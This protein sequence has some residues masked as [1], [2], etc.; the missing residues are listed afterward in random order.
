MRQRRLPFFASCRGPCP[1]A[2]RAISSPAVR[3]WRAAWRGMQRGTAKP[4]PCQVGRKSRSPCERGVCYAHHLR[5][6]LWCPVPPCAVEQGIACHFNLTWVFGM[7][8]YRKRERNRHTQEQCRLPFLRHSASD[9]LN[10][11]LTEI[12]P[13]LSPSSITLRS[14][15][16]QK[17]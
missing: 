10:K 17:N 4:P 13:F 14:V 3:L 8:W 9:L 1:P 15:Q 7:S 2:R 16:L 6:R 12:E 5:L 11:T